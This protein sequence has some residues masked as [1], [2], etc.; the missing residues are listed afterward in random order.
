MDNKAF[1]DRNGMT[2]KGTLCSNLGL[3]HTDG[4]SISITLDDRAVALRQARKRRKVLERC[5]KGLGSMFYLWMS[6]KLRQSVP[7][8]TNKV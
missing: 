2:F 8:V 4:V 1:K 7:T 5:L 3:V 6:T